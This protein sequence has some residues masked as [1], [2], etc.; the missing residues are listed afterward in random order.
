MAQG[1]DHK[2]AFNWWVKHVLKMRE[3]MVAG[4]RKQQL[5]YS[6]KSNK[7]DVELTKTVEQAFALD[8]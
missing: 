3:R 1:I 4:V 8:A 2:P 5:Q 7:F 6:K